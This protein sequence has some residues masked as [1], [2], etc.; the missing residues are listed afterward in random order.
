MPAILVETGFLSNAEDQ[1][2]LTDPERSAA[3]LEALLASIHEV[4]NGM[5]GAAP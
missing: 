2:L 1:R 5:P 3:I 4:R